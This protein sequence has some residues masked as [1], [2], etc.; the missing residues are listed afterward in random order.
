MIMWVII[1][2]EVAWTL[3]RFII[4][5]GYFGIFHD[6]TADDFIFGLTDFFL[7]FVILCLWSGSSLKSGKLVLSFGEEIDVLFTLKLNEWID[8]SCNNKVVIFVLVYQHLNTLLQLYHLQFI[9]F[10]IRG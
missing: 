10:F 5:E 8:I 4:D 6:E 9:P 3:G 7:S 1:S 2:R